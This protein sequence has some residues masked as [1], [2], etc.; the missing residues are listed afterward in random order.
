MLRVIEL[1]KGG[2]FELE[3]TEAFY[4]KVRAHYNLLAFEIPT[5]EHILSFF[6]ETSKSAFDKAENEMRRNGT[7]QED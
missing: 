1:P 2:T 7:W 6:R 5:D 3:Y 4:D